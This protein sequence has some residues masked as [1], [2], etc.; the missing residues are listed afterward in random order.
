MNDAQQAA[1]GVVAVGGAGKA[2]S[3]AAAKAMVLCLLAAAIGVSSFVMVATSPKGHR[4]LFLCIV[5]TAMTSICLG[6]YVGMRYGFAADIALAVLSGD[7]QALAA[8]SIIFIGVAFL[9]GLPA[10]CL[11]GSVFVWFESMRGKTI[12]EILEDAKRLWK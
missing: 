8:A 1:Q 2:A 10:W 6:C 11:I 12:V 3:L 9:C 5:S 4:N 7:L